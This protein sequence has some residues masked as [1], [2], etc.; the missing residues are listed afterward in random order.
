MGCVALIVAGGRGLRFG[1][2]IPKQFRNILDRPL[3]SWTVAPFEKAESIEE[4]VLVVPED[5]LLYAHEKV[6]SPFAFNKLKR[7][8][9]GG[10]SRRES[11]YRG[12][13][14]LPFSTGYVAIHDGARPVISTEDINRVVEAGMKERAALLARPVSDTIKRVQSEYII[15]TLD[16]G[17]LYGAETPQVFQYDLILAAHEK[18]AGNDTATDDAFLVESMGFK[19]RVVIPNGPNLKV[20][21]EDDLDLVRVLLKGR[22]GN[23][24]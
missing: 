18:A 21:S 7:I 19:V 1:G 5:Y 6:V 24:V 10:E 8:I 17:K 12:L 13:K 15:S 23:K 4:I 2:E 14:S 3:L 20:T 9:S 11:V 16:R 22:D